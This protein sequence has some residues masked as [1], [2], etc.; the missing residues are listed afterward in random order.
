MGEKKLELDDDEELL[1][2]LDVEDPPQQKEQSEASAEQEQAK[3]LS[4]LEKLKMQQEGKAP[5]KD[6][7]AGAPQVSPP[8]LDPNEQGISQEERIRRKKAEMARKKLE[9]QKA[10]VERKKREAE[11]AR[12]A[13]I[14]RKEEEEER[15]RLA[16]I[17]AEKERLRKIKEEEARKKAE[18]DELKKAF[19]IC[20]HEH[21]REQAQIEAEKQRQAE[22]EATR[23]I[24][25]AE[26]DFHVEDSEAEEEEEASLGI[27]EE[28][29]PY[30]K[31]SRR[32]MKYDI[33]DEND[34]GVAILD[35]KPFI[36]GQVII[37]P[38]DHYKSFSEVPSY[39]MGELMELAQKV[40]TALRRTD[41]H[42]EKVAI[43]VAENPK[44][45]PSKKH[46]Y[47][48]LHP[49]RTDDGYGVTVGKKAKVNKEEAERIY[50]QMRLLLGYDLD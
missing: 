31:I 28:S 13:E 1:M 45:D 33:L 41:L 47:L 30:C 16:A 48:S 6:P 43:F 38:R 17:E 35:P 36:S 4:R 40:A 46:F 15:K 27:F 50:R 21:E 18:E 24:A 19:G 22:E 11:E 26:L 5:A 42:I 7:Y 23:S 34:T 8:G 29:C 14:R 25:L 2:T 49:R 10:E 32:M 3:P 20:D 44:G 12:L 39:E 37:C 9:Q